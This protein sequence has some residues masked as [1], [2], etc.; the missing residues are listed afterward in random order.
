MIDFFPFSDITSGLPT[1]FVRFSFLTPSPITSHTQFYS[2]SLPIINVMFFLNQYQNF[3]Y[4]K[5]HYMKMFISIIFLCYV[6]HYLAC[7]TFCFS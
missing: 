6:A 5:I 7:L 3:L 2:F 4:M 1:N